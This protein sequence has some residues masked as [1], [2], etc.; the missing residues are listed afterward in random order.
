[1]D[2]HLCTACHTYHPGDIKA[3]PGYVCQPADGYPALIR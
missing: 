1:M 3:E 2:F